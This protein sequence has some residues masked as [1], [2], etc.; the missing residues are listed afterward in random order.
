MAHPHDVPGTAALAI[1]ESL[2]LALNDNK[3]LPETEIMAILTDAA[4]AHE[5]APDDGEKTEL[6]RAV[7][8]LIRRIIDG[9]NSVRRL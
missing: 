9:G 4:V 7:A 1:C 6:F 3:V 5:Q 8:K 2:L